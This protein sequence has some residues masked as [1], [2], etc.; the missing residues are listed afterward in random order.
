M[1]AD[2]RN[3]K[4]WHFAVAACQLAFSLCAFAMISFKIIPGPLVGLSKLF[5]PFAVGTFSSEFM[6][7]A[8]MINVGLIAFFGTKFW[9]TAFGFAAQLAVML[10]FFSIALQALIEL[11]VFA[12]HKAHLDFWNMFDLYS[13]AQQSEGGGIFAITSLQQP[14]FVAVVLP[15][16]LALL[17][18]VEAVIDV[19]DI[20]SVA[21]R[22]LRKEGNVAAIGFLLAGLYFFARCFNHVAHFVIPMASQI[23]REERF[24]QEMKHDLKHAAQ[25]ILFPEAVL[26]S[27]SKVMNR[28]GRTACGGLLLG[29]EYVPM[30]SSQVVSVLMRKTDDS[31]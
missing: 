30:W 25:R 13:R 26:S 9:L 16:T 18:A 24:Q 11:V 2:K 3:R 31:K 5:P 19:C 29:I 15:A 17:Y 12:L 1:I 6:F 23:L 10:V 22:H 20:E 14:L 28:L 8:I 4:W 7:L 27:V 21:A